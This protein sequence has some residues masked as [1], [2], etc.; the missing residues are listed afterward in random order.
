MMNHL[1]TSC[2][3]VLKKCALITSAGPVPSGGVHLVGALII[4]VGLSTL[5]YA[6]G[7][8]SEQQ[9]LRNA[10]EDFRT[11]RWSVVERS[12]SKLKASGFV[13]ASCE[14]KFLEGN[15]WQHRRPGQ[16]LARALA[17]YRWVVERHPEHPLAAW[18]LLATGRIHDLDVISPSP[19]AAIPV[20]REVM[21]RF[22]E[23]PAAQEAALHLSLALLQARGKDGG[24]QA[25]AML[26]SW[27]AA[28]P[29]PCYATQFELMLGKFYRYPLGNDRKAVQHLAVALDLR[30]ATLS[31]RVKTCWTIA[32][33]A[34]KDLKDR[35][36][37]VRYYTRFVKDFPMNRTVFMAKQ[38]LERLGA[39]LPVMEDY[40]LEGI[41]RQE[42]EM[43]SR[44]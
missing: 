38:A 9:A 24:A 4:L 17:A 8:P 6:E 33:L 29:D 14:A 40:S 19:E 37:A 34:E 10:W 18:A 27:H 28:H 31:Q 20:Y 3:S 21:D 11:G 1:P 35:E 16:D 25:V 26:E 7:T 13:D 5:G 23:S 32:T 30:P 41:R 15:L 42:R 36:L 44:H 43:R 2:S 22:P 39:P 12:L